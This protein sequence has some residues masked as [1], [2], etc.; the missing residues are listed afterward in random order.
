MLAI[1][2]GPGMDDFEDS[3]RDGVSTTGTPGTGLGAIRRMSDEFEVST[4]R[5][6]GTILRAVLWNRAPGT[7]LARFEIGAV[8]VPKTGE[9][10]CGD[11]WSMA[12][13]GDSVTLLVADGLGHGPEAS[14]AASLAV[15]LPH[16][17]PGEGPHRLVERAHGALRHTRGAALAILQHNSQRAQAV[18]AGIGNIGAWIIEGERR[19]ALVSQ[20]GIVGHNLHRIQEFR[21]EWPRGALLVLHSDGLETRWDLAKHPG[22][23]RAHA[24]VIAA[25]LYRRYSRGRDDVVVLVAKAL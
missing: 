21:Y 25:T 15:A 4:E 11:A 9:T 6:E 2:S 1:D 22:I 18:F 16:D 3:A 20:A 19:Q 12:V 24:S 7:P 23:V 17:H 14:R 5:G 10:V 13:D 8:V